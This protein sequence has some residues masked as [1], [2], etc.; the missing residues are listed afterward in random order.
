MTLA[1]AVRY[2]PYDYE[3]HEDRRAALKQRIV[4]KSGTGRS[5]VH[6]LTRKKG[7]AAPENQEE[8]IVA[9]CNELME[10]AF[11]RKGRRL[12]GVPALVENGWEREH[13]GARVRATELLVRDASPKIHVR[14]HTD[15]GG[16]TLEAGALGRVLFERLQMFSKRLANKGVVVVTAVLVGC[17]IQVQTHH[18][19]ALGLIRCQLFDLCG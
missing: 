3:I 9:L 6:A 15:G 4:T 2:S 19:H 16:E 1:S 11:T 5:L 7:K 14:S 13:V 10:I 18:W 17:Q 8:D 12:T